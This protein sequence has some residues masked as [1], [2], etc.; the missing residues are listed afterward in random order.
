MPYT[1]DTPFMGDN[2]RITVV[3]CGGTGGF[4]AEALCRLY[5]GRQ[6][7]IVLVDPR[8]GRTP[9]PAAAELPSPGTWGWHKS[10]ALA[11][12][13]SESYGRSVG[14]MVR[15]FRREEN[16]NYPGVKRYHPG[17][18]IGCVDNAQARQEMEDCLESRPHLWLIDA[19]QR[20]ELGAGPH[21]KPAHEMPKEYNQMR[22]GET[23][24]TISP[25]RRPRGPSC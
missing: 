25:A 9:Q 22:S 15:P 18:V 6:A 7:E 10:E 11:E 2:P 12:R 4:V 20:E 13:L 21:R 8:P 16:G 14:Y 23:S 5:T 17:V 3:G 24:A 19:G 1:L